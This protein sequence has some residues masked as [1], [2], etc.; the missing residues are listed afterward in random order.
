MKITIR[1]PTSIRREV[2]PVTPY[3]FRKKSQ[4]CFFEAGKGVTTLGRFYRP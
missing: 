3:S 4:G 2:F 1:R